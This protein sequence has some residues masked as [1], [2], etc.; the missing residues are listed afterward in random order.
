MW[1][2]YGAVLFGACLS[3]STAL[4]VAGVAIPT[5]VVQML[6][7]VAVMVVL[8]VAGRNAKLPAALGAAYVRGER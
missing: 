8:L 2:L 5:D 3:A 1:V 4:Q 7:F 6:P